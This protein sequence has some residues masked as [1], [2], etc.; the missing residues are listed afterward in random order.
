MSLSNYDI[1]IGLEIHAELSTKTKVF[2]ACENTFGNE[3]NT[4]CCPVCMGFPGALPVLNGA[5]VQKTVLAGL[6]FGCTINPTATFERKNYFYPDLAKAYQI[7]QLEKP[8]CLGGGIMLKSGKFARLNRIHLEEDAGKLTHSGITKQTMIDYN[9]GGIPL[10]EIVTEPDFSSA[11]EVHEFLEEVRARL[12][13]AG[14]ADCRMEQGGMRC[15]VNLSL[16]PKGAALLGRRTETKNLNSF[17]MVARAIEFEAERQAELL[18]QGKQVVLETRKWNDASGKTTSMRSKEESQDYRYF[19]DPD[20]Y[21]VTISQSDINQFKQN[22]PT[23]AWQYKHKFMQQYGLPEYDA[24]ILTTDKYI[25]TYFENC[26]GLLNMP[27]KI[28]NWLMV[29]ML[30]LVKESAETT[31]PITEE[32]FTQIIKMVEEKAF[33]RAV[34]LQVLTEVIASGIA[35]AQIAKQKGLLQAVSQETVLQILQTLKIQNPKLTADFATDPQKVK[36]YIIGQV[37]RATQG[38]VTPTLVETL[39]ADVFG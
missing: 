33:T 18:S 8:L 12:V 30:K 3:P 17:K 21:A 26:V 10:I 22:M 23:L 14:V 5:A 16:K 6:A 28:A 34:G 11:Q 31:F 29:D 19:P 15:D 20:I 35:P 25:T 1:V 7:S 32:H 13:F 37:M 9:R 24:S 4:N 27:K 36:A 38:K 2:C 39:L